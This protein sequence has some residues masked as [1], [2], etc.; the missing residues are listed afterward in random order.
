MQVIR[1]I[2]K[3]SLFISGFA[4]ILIYFITFSWE[5]VICFLLGSVASNL[6]FF[7][8]VKFMDVSTYRGAMSKTISTFMLSMIFY[9]LAMIFG[10]KFME[11]TGL[12]LAFL[13]C[14][15]IRISILIMGI[16]GGIIDG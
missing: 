12:I 2:Q 16:K 9:A 5:Y 3:T 11:L 14:L 13:G 10:Y 15:A 4:M 7:L 6:S 1:Q 8:N